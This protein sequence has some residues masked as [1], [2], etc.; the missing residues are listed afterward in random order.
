[1]RM[2]GKRFVFKYNFNRYNIR[3]FLL[4]NSIK[5]EYVQH[6][7]LEKTR[8]FFYVLVYAYRKSV[9]SLVQGME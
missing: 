9:F 3:N 4:Y 6:S 8:F 5:I 1:M 7:E 2:L